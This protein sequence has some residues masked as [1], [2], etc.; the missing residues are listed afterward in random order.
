MA[1]VLWLHLES[2][3]SRTINYVLLTQQ[4]AIIDVMYK[5][6]EVIEEDIEASQIIQQEQL[7]ELGN[8]DNDEDL[9][10]S[11]LALRMLTGE[12]SSET[13][14]DEYNNDEDD[15]AEFNNESPLESLPPQSFRY[16]QLIS[17]VRNV[18]KNFKKSPTKN[19]D[20]L[21]KHVKAD[22]GQDYALL[23]D[24]KTRWSSIDTML[25]R[26]LNIKLYF[27]AYE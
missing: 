24:G 20:V 12:I 27:T 6:N 16:Q 8:F 25:S 19:D 15:A 1:A 2:P 11:E 26:F 13:D 5:R 18:V 17:K 10:L 3:S 7:D 14:D 21:Q 22:F 9:P 23:L 4:L